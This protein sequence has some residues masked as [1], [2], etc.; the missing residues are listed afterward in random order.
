M[1]FY[2]NLNEMEKLKLKLMRK[3]L[4]KLLWNK[5]IFV[6]HFHNLNKTK[7]ISM[8]KHSFKDEHGICLGIYANQNV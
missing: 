1:T 7:R 6:C 8:M 2:L 4:Q 5:T 3:Y